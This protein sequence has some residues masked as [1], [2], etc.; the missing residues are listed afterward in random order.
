MKRKEKEIYGLL[1]YPLGHS[2]SPLM[3]NAALRALKINAE[4]K[5]FALPPQKLGDFLRDSLQSNIRGLNVTIPYKEKVLDLCLL[6]ENSAYLK[7]VKA[8][9]TLVKTDGLWKAFNTDIAGF[10]RHLKEHFSPFNKKAA[11]LGAGGAAR[12]VAY[13]LANSGVKEMVIFDIDRAKSQGI[14]NMICS[15]FPGFPVLTVD[16]IGE[17]NIR[18]KDLLINATPIGLKKT[19][20]SLVKREMLHKNLFVYDLIYNPAQTKLLTLAG[21]AGA[22]FTN[23]LGML[24]YQGALSFE[25]FTGKKAP[26]G[27]MRRAL[28]KGVKKC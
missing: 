2:L 6:D 7:Q 8:V 4:Y 20:P 12:A 13:V 10:S 19:D 27:L 5:L 11:I 25:Y 3:H 18:Q 16:S 17:L 14:V 15:L 23:G 24:L 9:N 22:K 1:G 21:Q 28:I 26:L